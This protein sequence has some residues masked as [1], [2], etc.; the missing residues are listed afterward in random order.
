[1]T[2][3]YAA[4]FPTPAAREHDALVKL[5]AALHDLDA[6]GHALAYVASGLA[7]ADRFGDTA[8]AATG[9]RVLQTALDDWQARAAGVQAAINRLPSTEDERRAA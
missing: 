6:A 4:I 7:V 1:M 9:R 5:L 3:N 2:L 8:N